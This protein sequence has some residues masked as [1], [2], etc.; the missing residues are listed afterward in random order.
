MSSHSNNDPN[1]LITLAIHTY[2]RAV[3]LKSRLEQAGVTSVLHNVNLSE[4]VVSAGVRVRI[5]EKDLPQALAVVE[6][7]DIAPAPSTPSK[8]MKVLIPV[9]FSDYSIKSCIVGF[10]YAR[11]Y[12]GSVVLLHAYMNAERRLAL[13]FG[14]DR[15]KRAGDDDSTLRSRALLAMKDFRSKLEKMIVDGMLANV[16]FETAVREGVAEH[17]VL[18]CA[19]EVKAQMIVMG[20]AG[21]S[22][23]ERAAL[24]SV[25]AEVLDAC[26]F[27]I[28]AIPKN[29]EVDRL[30][31]VKNVV[32]FSNLIPNDLLSFDL[33]SHLLS[34]KGMKVNIVP[35][36][37]KRAGTKYTQ[38]AKDQLMNYCSE[39]Y[40]Q[41]HFQLTEV[42]LE[43][44][45]DA[46]QKFTEEK[47]IDLIVIPNKKT[48][49][50]A[51]L[52][53]PSIAHRV[54]FSSDIPLLAVPV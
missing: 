6:S 5:R 20:T 11:R 35:V 46:F 43:G 15:Y 21:T 42:P 39:H 2:D 45:L 3:I 8:G 54:L 17:C 19:D 22:Q 49:I 24:G 33:F 50:F 30:A 51:R 12:S 47:N 13:P 4:P 41:C 29:A 28:M 7:E 31:S 9:D 53:N 26:R 36:L 27:P 1:R 38:E 18:T 23:R 52:F 16:S 48:N 44:N 34:V 10:E 32:F 37:E 40:P 14:S 25:T